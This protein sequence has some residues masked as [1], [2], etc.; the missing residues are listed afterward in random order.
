[1]TGLWTWFG[2][3]G[4]KAKL[5][6]VLLF[7]GI[8]PFAVNAYIAQDRAGKALEE[9]A[10][11]QLEG[12]REIKKNQLVSYF[13]ER[14]GDVD[15]LVDMVSSLRAEG[16]AKLQT[17]QTVKKH[18]LEEYFAGIFAD[19]SVMADNNAV[20]EAMDAFQDVHGHMGGTDTGYDRAKEQYGSWLKKYKEE[21]GFYDL[22]LLGE[23][24]DVIYTVKEG[25][26]LGEN[27][28]KGSL[29]NS[30]LA[31]CFKEALRNTA[32]S[33]F[34]P[35]APSN[36]QQASF[37]G[38]P[39]HKG[40]KVIGVLAIQLNT[41]QV[42]TIVQQ[43]EG[44][45]ETFE[46]YLV[47]GVK[48][49]G[50]LR[51][52]RVIKE[53][54]IGD[55]KSGAD[56]DEVLSGRAGQKTKV[57]STGVLELASYVPLEIAG[58][59]WGINTT[60]ALQE[61]VAPKAE[62]ES[63]DFFAKYQ[64]AYGYYDVFLIDSNGYCFYSVA[65]E[66][67]FQ[68]NL[69]NGK[70][71][72]T[73]LGRLIRKV[74]SSRKTE[75][76]DF[77]RYAPS[78]DEPAAFLAKPLIHGGAIELYVAV[79]LPV[80]GVDK[81]MSESTGLGVSGETY[82]VG[83]DLLMR[84]DSRFEQQS[85][86]L[87]MKID[88][89]GTRLAIEDKVGVAIMK[90]YHGKD[91][92]NAYSHT[93]FNEALGTDFDWAILAEIDKDEALSAVRKMQVTTGIMAVVIVVAVVFLALMFAQT[94]AGPITA[95][96]D[97]VKRVA[98]E[99]DLTLDVPVASKDEIGTMALEFNNMLGVL[100]Q[101][102]HQ[103]QSVSENVATSAEDVAGRA[104][105]NR[106]RS[107]FEL[108]QAQKSQKLIEAMGSTAGK[109]AQASLAQQKAAEKSKETV[110][111]LLQSMTS[112]NEAAA[113]Q[114][115]E[116]KTAT[117]RVAEM[118]ATGA[119]V[120]ETSGKQGEMVM[121]VTASMN[122]ISTAVQEMA[123]AVSSA[124]E[125]GKESLTSADDGKSA[126]ENTVVSMR[127]IADSSE[128]ISEII[129]VITEI[130]EQTNLLALNAA[131]EAARAGEHGR[132]FAV[133]ADEVGK[134]A[135]RSSEAANEI[136]QLIKDST[137]RVNEGTKITEGL[138][139]SL[140][141]I[142]KSGRNNMESIVHISE[143]ARVVETDIQK[144][145]TLVETL[146]A[147]AQEISVMAGEQG[148]RRQ[149]A[150]LALGTMVEQSAIIGTLVSDAN[151]GAHAIDE[152][153]KGIVERTEELSKMVTLQGQRSKAASDIAVQSAAGALKTKEGAGTVVAITS[154]LQKFSQN[155]QEQ[156]RQFKI[157][158]T[159]RRK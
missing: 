96:V 87:K 99:R 60:G 13:Q 122:E 112:V 71:S 94:I 86:I 53:G 115:E 12:I 143:S 4:L 72:N 84:S 150:E 74:G 2:D 151:T 149:A 133:V 129:G 5:I 64:K 26:D 152:E 35:Y 147:M 15:V 134:L 33:D 49:K 75:I 50:Y 31:K 58:L 148:A 103:V 9:N 45:G 55:S 146:N 69:L 48:G 70:Y 40:G 28:V 80:E 104:A 159:G 141:K 126:V 90:D 111:G 156:V 77:E 32:I 83:Q 121:K 6:W 19:V 108:E 130:A 110:V 29:R 17:V 21:Q 124:T 85:T 109:V 8:V 59:N 67:D 144:V 47:G 127:A 138:Q 73:N 119:K 95:I 16:F 82:L 43:R 62:G 79:Q 153:M 68:T 24:G 106:D 89:E 128:Q 78:N 137:N 120:V 88:T 65:H 155:L 10:F 113:K 92:L 23:D 34:E 139:A 142:E 7:V 36:N 76:A 132:G 27:V 140:V 54:K 11:S 116:A 22:F 91:V 107:E 42:N 18:Q 118:G 125:H 20:L 114:N 14:K 41:E 101:S 131:I 52:D 38:A 61:V 81:I 158:S 56:V 46:S 30:G 3:L 136:T 57:G 37:I 63:E 25:S 51:S 44:L 100:D 105:A 117:N 102:F 123:K 93:G 98:S 157:S 1:M 145:Q 154:D 135:Q 97:V 66:A 39:I